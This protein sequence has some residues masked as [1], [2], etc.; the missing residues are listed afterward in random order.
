MKTAAM[1]V[2]DCTET[3][4]EAERDRCRSICRGA[5]GLYRSLLHGSK[6][7]VQ[8]P[9][10]MGMGANN[11]R[12]DRVIWMRDYRIAPLTVLQGIQM[13]IFIRYFV[14]DESR[15]SVMRNLGIFST[16]KWNEIVDV[17]R[18][19]IGRELERKHLW[20]I[21]EYIGR[22]DAIEELIQDATRFKYP[23]SMRRP[24]LDE[25]E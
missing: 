15:D 8:N 7:K 3:D 25:R 6:V 11:A 16:G 17:I 20:P 19:K 4:I 14:E 22:C 2:I 12:F 10:H 24:G 9:E 18:E 21:S 13:T 23:R 5:H 1:A